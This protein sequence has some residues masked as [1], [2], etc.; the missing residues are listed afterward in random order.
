[1]SED[2]ILNKEFKALIESK[3]NEYYSAFVVV[4]FDENYIKSLNL[5]ERIS[6]VKESKNK[7][8]KFV[9]ENDIPVYNK[10]EFLPSMSLK[11]TG[12][13][14][15]ELSKQDYV[16]YISQGDKIIVRAY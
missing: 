4:Y 15:L 7:L 11:M 2:K 9:E 3:P 12:K 5:K 16:R 6:R 10:L 13:Q 14:I 1:M 8:E